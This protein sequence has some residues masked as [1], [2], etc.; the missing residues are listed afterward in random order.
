[1]KMDKEYLMKK[2]KIEELQYTTFELKLEVKYER[3]S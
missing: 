2:E 3:K 1:M